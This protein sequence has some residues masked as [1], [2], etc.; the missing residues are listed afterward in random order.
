LGSV[1]HDASNQA[2]AFAPSS[3]FQLLR[4]SSIALSVCQ[5]KT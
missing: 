3:T 5:I 2:A 4:S 1:P